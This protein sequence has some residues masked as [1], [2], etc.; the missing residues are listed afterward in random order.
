M[1]AIRSLPL[2]PGWI[3]SKGGITSSDVATVALGTR[4]AFVLGQLLPG[5]PVWRLDGGRYPGLVLVVFPG[6]VGDDGALRAAVSGL[7]RASP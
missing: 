1:G 5:V 7:A 3:L 2:R 4:S 6:N